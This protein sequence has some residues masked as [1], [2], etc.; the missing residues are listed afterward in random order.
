VPGC[1]LF[2][3]SGAHTE[4]GSI[5]LHSPLFDF[6]DALLLPGAQYFAAIARSQ[7]G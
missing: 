5:P 2:I 6:N 7:L 3:G 1:Y 4:P